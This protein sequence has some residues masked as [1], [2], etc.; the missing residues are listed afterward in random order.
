MKNIEH[1]DIYRTQKKR[2][3]FIE[4]EIKQID[5]LMNYPNCIGD[6]HKHDFY[7]VL[8]LIDGSSNQIVDFNREIIRSGQI[9]LMYPGQIHGFNYK[10]NS[11]GFTMYFTDTFLNN[12][13][14]SAYLIHQ[15]LYNQRQVV[16]LNTQQI[17]DLHLNFKLLHNEFNN[18]LIN[19]TELLKAHTEIILTKLLRQLTLDENRLQSKNTFYKL[20][21]LREKYYSKNVEIKS[22]SEALGYSPKKLNTL[23][24][25]YFGKTFLQF[26]NERKLLEVK[27]LLK[28]SDLSN[29]E[30][31]YKCGF[32]DTSYLNN[33]FKKNVGITPSVFRNKNI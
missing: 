26:L 8:F 31:A 15:L 29:K 25:K 16:H 4:F 5:D 22:I 11:K 33:Y 14:S 27:R 18:D 2:N 19:K 13:D 7:F 10:K 12:S 17:Q 20:I 23:T 1:R 24:K 6:L 3:A 21:A 30:I 9:L 32:F 28:T